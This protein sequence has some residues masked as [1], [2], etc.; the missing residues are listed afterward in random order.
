M[1]IAVAFVLCSVKPIYKFDWIVLIPGLLQFEINGANVS[2][3]VTELGYLMIDIVKMLS[4]HVIE[5]G[6]FYD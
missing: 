4:A 1:K 3:N 5:V 6:Y 2:V